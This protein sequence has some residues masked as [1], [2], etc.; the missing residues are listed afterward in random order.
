LK[1][2]LA[3]GADPNIAAND[4]STVLY[5]AARR[6]NKDAVRLLL[7]DGRV[8]ATLTNWE[9]HTALFA[10]VGNTHEDAAG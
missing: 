8:D 7:D 4:G 2:L 9:G 5:E 10:A 6:G 3:R 1:K